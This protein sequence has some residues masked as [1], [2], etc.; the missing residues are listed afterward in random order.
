MMLTTTAAATKPGFRVK[1][2][3]KRLKK[4]G[5]RVARDRRGDF[6]RIGE[7]FKDIANDEQRRSREL[8]EQ[9]REF[10]ENGVEE[11]VEDT[12]IDFFDLK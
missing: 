5:K 12:S 11:K 4:F 1:K 8:L 3:Q 10:F 7:R 6:A 2:V 9:H